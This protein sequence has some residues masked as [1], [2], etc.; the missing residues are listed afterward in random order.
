MS[1]EN[2]SKALSSG[3]G[4]GG[5]VGR[6][7]E[8]HGESL[9]DALDWEREVSIRVNVHTDSARP[10]SSQLAPAPLNHGVAEWTRTGYLNTLGVVLSDSA[11]CDAGLEE[12]EDGEGGSLGHVD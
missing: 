4:K 9:G 8:G 11:I 5:N 12:R 2:A 10:G 7:I 6:R 3:E 1:L